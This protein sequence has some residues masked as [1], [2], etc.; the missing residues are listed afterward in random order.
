[1]EM[2]TGALVGAVQRGG[3][4]SAPLNFAG[5]SPLLNPLPTRS[6]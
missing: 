2:E 1:M 6:S 4:L 5:A 3:S